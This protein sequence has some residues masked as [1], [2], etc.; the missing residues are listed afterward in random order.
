[1]SKIQ[2]LIAKMAIEAKKAAREVAKLST[3]VKN[4]VLLRTAERIIEAREKLQEENE[5]DLIKAKNKGVTSAF[6]DRLKLSDRVIDSMAEGLRD[7]GLPL[8]ALSDE[9]KS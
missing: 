4:D 2:S 7:V 5:K 6:M 9:V 8:P 1:M 3:T